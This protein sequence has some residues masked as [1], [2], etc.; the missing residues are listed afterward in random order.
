MDAERHTHQPVV[1]RHFSALNEG[2]WEL[3]YGD[4]REHICAGWR[5]PTERLIR[6]AFSRAVTRH[7]Q[8]SV[9]A[10]GRE[11]L[12]RRLQL[13]VEVAQSWPRR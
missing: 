7:D 4:T 5:K 10:G 11:G 9:E 8:G 12:L 6:N 3:K 2:A 13:E 1:Q